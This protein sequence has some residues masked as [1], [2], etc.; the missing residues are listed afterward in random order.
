VW[1]HGAGA[2]CTA[3]RVKEGFP[4]EEA[5]EFRMMGIQSRGVMEKLRK[6]IA[7]LETSTCEGLWLRAR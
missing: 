5:Y 7:D 2:P 4:E 6:N 3:L 1:E